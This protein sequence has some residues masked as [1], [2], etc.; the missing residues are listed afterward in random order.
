MK[1]GTP[2][3]NSSSSNMLIVNASGLRVEETR[4]SLT[5][6]RRKGAKA[7]SVQFIAH[8]LQDKCG[9]QTAH[10][11]S[12]VR[13]TGPR[14]SGAKS[15][16]PIA[17]GRTD[18]GSPTDRNH[19][20]KLPFRAGSRHVKEP[21]VPASLFAFREMESGALMKLTREGSCLLAKSAI[22]AFVR[23]ELNEMWCVA[24]G[25]A[26][27]EF[28]KVRVERRLPAGHVQEPGFA[29]GVESSFPGLGAGETAQFSP[30]RRRVEETIRAAIV[31]RIQ[32]VAVGF[33]IVVQIGD[34]ARRQK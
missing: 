3:R 19:D 9:H 23:F 27:A 33:D 25:Q 31:A 26:A 17:L 8:R 12:W 15:R 14:R 32:G 18:G 28:D 20:R 30:I 10:R 34:L 29:G 11:K 6:L 16:L 7:G 2:A 4:V 22:D 24:R 1:L 21:G 13:E 5:R